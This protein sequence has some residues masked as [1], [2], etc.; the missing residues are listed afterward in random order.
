MVLN[1]L[2]VPNKKGE[3]LMKF[4]GLKPRSHCGIYYGEAYL[5]RGE[6]CVSST[7]SL[8]VPQNIFREIFFYFLHTPQEIQLWGLVEKDEDNE[9][10]VEELV[11]APQFQ[12]ML[13]VENDQDAFPDW[14]ESL[15]RAGKD[16]NKLRLQVHSH[17]L[18]KAFFSGED[19]RTIC[20]GYSCD[21]MISMVGDRSGMLL[22]RLDIFEPVPLSL[23]LPIFVEPSV[24]QFTPEE[25]ETWNQKLMAAGL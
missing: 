13:H 1:Q 9:F 10:T 22:A 25:K 16:I 21:W 24:D 5:L 6:Q 3:K 7:P 20:E 11:L 4:L 17:G 18:A 14:L 2:V 8:F 12:E 15:E 19:I 23:A